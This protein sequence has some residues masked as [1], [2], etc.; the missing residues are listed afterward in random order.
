MAAVPAVRVGPSGD[1]GIQSARNP[2]GLQVLE[3]R[4]FTSFLR[5]KSYDFLSRSALGRS[6]VRSLIGRA[7][8][9]VRGHHRHDGRAWTDPSAGR[10]ERVRDQKR[11]ARG[12]VFNHFPRCSAVYRHRPYSAVDPDHLSNFGALAPVAYVIPLWVG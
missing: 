11:C 5:H 8:D 9:L 12:D 7:A 3:T 10:H 4:D 1:Y 2:T 6:E